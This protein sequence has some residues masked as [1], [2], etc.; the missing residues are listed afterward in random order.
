MVPESAFIRDPLWLKI[1]TPIAP[2]VQQ[3]ESQKIACQEATAK[4]ILPR[5]Q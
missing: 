4:I 2:I 1:Q 3:K 5:S